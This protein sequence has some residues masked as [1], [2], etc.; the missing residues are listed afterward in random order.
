MLDMAASP[1]PP[2]HPPSSSARRSRQ[3]FSLVEVTLAIGLV[4]ISIL[5]LLGIMPVGLN[6]MRDAM[7]STARAQIAQQVAGEALL[8]PF[9]ELDN[10]IKA[11][12]YYFTQEGLLLEKKDPVQTRFEVTLSRD[13]TVYP[14]SEKADQLE[15]SITA[16]KVEV[17]LSTGSALP[18]TYVLQIPNSGE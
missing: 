18:F 6:T 15:K 17:R 7:D 13:S 4:A 14:G 3:A 9:A 2:L 12:P 1:L 11:G 5:T 8:K 16:L 10:Y